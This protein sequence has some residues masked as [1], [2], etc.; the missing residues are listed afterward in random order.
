MKVSIRSLL[1]L[2]LLTTSTVLHSEDTVYKF[3]DDLQEQ[4]YQDLINELRCLVCQN[5]TLAD[6]NAELAQDLRH[7]VYEMIVKGGSDDTIIE[8]LVN[9]YGDFV[10]YRPPLKQTT[11]ILWFGPL[12]MMVFALFAAFRIIINRKAENSGMP[13]LSDE[14]RKKLADLLNQPEAGGS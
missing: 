1:L 11:W 14:E 5:Q 7:E 2:L 13:V 3:K 12:L 10:L 8:F 4:R 9:R 6:S